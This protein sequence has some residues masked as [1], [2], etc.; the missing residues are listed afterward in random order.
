MLAVTAPAPVPDF[1]LTSST[2]SKT[3]TQGSSATYSFSIAPINGFTGQ[4]NLSVS[5]LPAGAGGTFSPNPVTGSS[6]LTVTTGASTP[7]NSYSLT[8][9]GASGTLSHAVSVSMTVTAQSGPD[10]TLTS[11]TPTKTMQQANTSSYSFAITP[12]NGFT[13]QVNL[14]VSGLPTGAAGTFSPNPAASASTLTVTTGPST[15]AGSYSLKITGVSGTLT[16]STTV[17]LN[18]TVQ[19]FTLTSSTSGQTAQGGTASYSVTITPMNGFTG[20][21]NLSVSG[22]PTGAGGVFYPNPAAANSYT[23]LVSTASNTPQGSYSLTITGVAGSLS[24]SAVVSLQVGSTISVDLFNNGRGA[25]VGTLLSV[26][27]L[28]AST[29]GSGG[30]WTTSNIQKFSIGA[31]NLGVFADPVTVAGASY[32]GSGSQSWNYDHS[33]D[34]QIVTYQVPRG[35]TRMSLGMFVQPG[36]YGTWGYF[37]FAWFEGRTSGQDCVLQLHDFP[38]N[39]V[40]QVEGWS[41]GFGTKYGVGIPV[42]RNTAYWM[43]LQYDSVAGLCSIAVFDPVTFVQIGVT[44]VVPIDK[45]EGVATL[46]LGSNGHGVTTHAN[47]L[48]DNI[49]VDWTGAKFPLIPR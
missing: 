27:I 31:S 15:S 36:P 13:G 38:T 32:D 49:L 3:V 5:G 2:P 22:L 26:P 37:D 10:F 4:V 19:D 30:L 41:P 18:V 35:R 9:T 28:N 45:N 25:N 12:M 24:H 23:L 20:Q 14:S 33:V 21:V 11:Q 43:S 39:H 40:M 16:H 48:M 42:S 6:T 44:S 17:S 47:T 1:T 7:A 8:I 46:N 34:N 29:V